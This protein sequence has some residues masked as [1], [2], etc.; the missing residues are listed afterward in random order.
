MLKRETRDWNF[1]SIEEELRDLQSHEMTATAAARRLASLGKYKQIKADYD[2]FAR[3]MEETTRRDAELAAAQRARLA[4]GTIAP[5]ARPQTSTPSNN[6]KQAPLTNPTRPN[7]TSA[8][9]RSPAPAMQSRPTPKNGRFDGAGIIQR[10]GANQAG[11]PKHVLMHPNGQRLAYLYG[12]GV[13]LDKYLGESMGLEGERAY[14][15]ELK[16]DLLIV[17]SLQPVN[18]KP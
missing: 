3:I 18:L 9:T 14:R 12:D 17:K 6:I 4:P 16:S 10:S 8:P 7:G 11:L 13:D 15:P 5:V 1:S 2:E